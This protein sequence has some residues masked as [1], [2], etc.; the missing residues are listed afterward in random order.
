METEFGSDF[1]NTL[2]EMNPALRND[3]HFLDLDK[4]LVVEHDLY[5]NC[6]KK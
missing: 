1:T 2:L 6:L 5:P 3:T 4:I